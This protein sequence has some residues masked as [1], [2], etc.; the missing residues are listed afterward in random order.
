MVLLDS[1]ESLRE[2][3]LLKWNSCEEETSK[4]PP[5]A[6]V[7]IYIYRF[8]RHGNAEKPDETGNSFVGS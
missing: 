6:P 4:G 7:Y 8:A 2:V 5:F 1:R 3:D